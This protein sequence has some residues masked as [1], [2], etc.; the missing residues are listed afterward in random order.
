MIVPVKNFSYPWTSQDRAALRRLNS[1]ERIQNFLDSAIY[2]TGD[3][4]LMPH[5]VLRQ[6]CAH[7][8]DG[9]VFA[10]T[11]FAENKHPPLLLDLRAVRDDDHVLAVFKK[12]GRFGAVA[13]SNYVGL[14][15]RE[16]VYRSVRE[17]A[18]SYFES[19]FNL[20]AEKTLREFS[21]PFLL[22]RVRNL[23]WVRGPEVF[24]DIAETLDRQRH[25][26]LLS[27]REIR[28]LHK[29]DARSFLAGQVGT[30]K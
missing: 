30:R 4:P 28:G 18:V 9:A 16:P 29:V 22:T 7:C 14:R 1:P 3:L 24:D 5:E 27:A 13:K 21:N 20:K 8:F 19:Y 11:C 10:A 2:N 6:K 15:F 25:F 17:L 12:H 26:Q 23:D